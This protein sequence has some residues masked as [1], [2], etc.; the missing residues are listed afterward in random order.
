[1]DADHKIRGSPAPCLSPE[2]SELAAI[3]LSAHVGH[4][5]VAA[6]V[7]VVEQIVAGVIRVVVN[8]EVLA[9]VP[10]PI[11]AEA[12]IPGSHFKIKAT[13]KPEAVM[14]RSMRNTL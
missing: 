6:G 13:G 1:M 10:A 3:Q 5:D 2:D 4:M 12:P 7:N 8:G 14:S 9:A 11:G